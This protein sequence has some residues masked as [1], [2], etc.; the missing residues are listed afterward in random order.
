MVHD[1]TGNSSFAKA[2]FASS[3]ARPELDVN[4]PDFW[5]KLLPERSNR[6]DPKILNLPRQRKAIQRFSLED[7]EDS[8]LELS[9][10][11][12]GEDGDLYEEEEVMGDD[13]YEPPSEAT[14]ENQQKVFFVGWSQVARNR[15]QKGILLFGYGR[16]R[17]I[18]N[19]EKIRRPELVMELYGRAYLRKLCAALTLELDEALQQLDNS[20]ENELEDEK[21]SKLAAAKAKQEAPAQETLPNQVRVEEMDIEPEIKPEATATTTTTTDAASVDVRA[22]EMKAEDQVEEM[23]IEE[24]ISAPEP[25]ADYVKLYDAVYDEDRALNEPSFLA[26]LKQTSKTI[27]KR[28]KLLSM[29]GDLVRSDFRGITEENWPVAAGSGP[30]SSEYP[31]WWT[32]KHDKDLLVGTYKH[33]FGR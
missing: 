21:D 2:S 5:T 4:D 6:P 26:K 13:E 3:S 18:R 20:D 17:K 12:Q 11:G 7:V 15:M 29:L 24:P 14:K 10:D 30:G 8:D 19:V 25:E 9:G 32:A 28:L 33:G 31:D 23:K 16:W 1:Q 27:Y 22:E